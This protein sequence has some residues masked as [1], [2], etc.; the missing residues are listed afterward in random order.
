MRHSDTRAQLPLFEGVRETLSSEVGAPIINVAMVPQRSPFRYPGGK[1]W[2]VPKFRDWLKS[3]HYKPEI[4]LEPFAGGGIISLTAAFE[5]LAHRIIMVEIDND[6]SAVWSAILGQDA[7]WLADKIMSFK[8]TAETAH[9]ELNKTAQSTRQ[10]AFQTLLK[11]RI[12]H[13]GILAPGSG[14]IKNGENGKG[15]L[16]RWYPKTLAKRILA[17][18]E[19]RHKITFIH[20]DGLQVIKQF[21]KEDTAAFFIDPPY[22]VAG[23]KAGARLYRHNA[24]D[25]EALFRA[26]QSVQGDFLMTYD[27]ADAVI[28]LAKKFGFQYTTIT[29]K[30]THHATM[31]ELVISG[32]FDWSQ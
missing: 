3:L 23:K 10:K 18:G 5:D 7:R 12:Y 27:K 11:N 20:G 9:E 2:L 8:L 29:M 17:I 4:F 13:G 32:D 31:E 22:T 21:A 1:T 25:H 24:L 30:N 16:S 19:V 28:R 14:L 15:I 26:C 6:V